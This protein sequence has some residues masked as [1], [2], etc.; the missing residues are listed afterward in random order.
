MCDRQR[1]EERFNGFDIASVIMEEMN[2]CKDC[3]I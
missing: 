2:F 1:R 3:Y